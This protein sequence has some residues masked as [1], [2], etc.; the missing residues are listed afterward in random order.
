MRLVWKIAANSADSPIAG[1]VAFEFLTGV[2]NGSGCFAAN[3]AVSPIVGFG[4]Y[5]Y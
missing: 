5:H 4:F 2:R 1:S 3:V